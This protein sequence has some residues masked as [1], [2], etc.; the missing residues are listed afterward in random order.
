M[1]A[2]QAGFSSSQPFSNLRSISSLSPVGAI[3][4]G[5]PIFARA[6]RPSVRFFANVTSSLEGE[7]DLSMT[8]RPKTAIDGLAT[9][10]PARAHT[11]TNALELSLIA[12]DMEDT[13]YTVIIHM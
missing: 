2:I 6:R 13:P 5:P 1:P 8:S 7:P 3:E 12:R 11:T 10:T 4:Y 9:A